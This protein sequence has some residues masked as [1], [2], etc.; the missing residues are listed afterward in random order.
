MSMMLLLAAVPGHCIYEHRPAW[1]LF[2]PMKAMHTGSFVI[3]SRAVVLKSES[4]LKSVFLLSRT[5]LRLVGI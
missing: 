2:M 5:C 4:R 3:I 1:C